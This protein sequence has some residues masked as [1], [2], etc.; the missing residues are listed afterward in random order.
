MQMEEKKI[1]KPIRF[2]G[3][4]I[5]TEIVEEPIS[6]TN[7]REVAHFCVDLKIL[8]LDLSLFKKRR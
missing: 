8:K 5:T 1:I 6:E 4:P 3:E 2:Y 7:R